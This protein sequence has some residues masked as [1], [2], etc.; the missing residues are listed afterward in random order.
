[1][2]IDTAMF[3]DQDT[4]AIGIGNFANEASALYMAKRGEDSLWMRL[5]QRVSA[6]Y[7]AGPDFWS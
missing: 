4:L 2:G 3:R 7:Q 6:T 5:W 1:M